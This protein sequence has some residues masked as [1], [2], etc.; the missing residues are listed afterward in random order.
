MERAAGED[1]QARETAVAAR[2]WVHRAADDLRKRQTLTIGL[3]AIGAN[4]VAL[5]ARLRRLA[6]EDEI[7]APEARAKW[8][9]SLDAANAELTRA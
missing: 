8:I 3:A 5:D 7:A 9:E 6:Q 2:Q 4:L 1:E